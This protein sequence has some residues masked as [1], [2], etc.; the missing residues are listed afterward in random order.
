MKCRVLLQGVHDSHARSID[1]EQEGFCSI[2]LVFPCL[3]AQVQLRQTKLL[4][5]QSTIFYLQQ[6]DDVP[7]SIQP[8][9]LLRTPDTCPQFPWVNDACVTV[10]VLCS[11]LLLGTAARPAWQVSAQ[12]ATPVWSH[13]CNGDGIHQLVKLLKETLN[14]GVCQESIISLS[15]KS[16]LNSLLITGN[17]NASCAQDLHISFWLRM[18]RSSS[19]LSSKKPVLIPPFTLSCSSED[20]R[21]L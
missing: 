10:V 2:F 4:S 18:F 11:L 5:L 17:T 15:H 1:G 9:A 16:S 19:L 21:L 12:V 3:L 8:H 13:R 6:H 14:G 7:W 20:R